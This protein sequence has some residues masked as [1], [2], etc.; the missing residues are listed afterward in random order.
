M[1]QIK[2]SVFCN[3]KKL[4]K[5]FESNG[6]DFGKSYSIPFLAAFF[7][8]FLPL[9][10]KF[11]SE[12][13][14]V[15]DKDKVLGFISVEKDER[16]RKRL[17]ITKVFLEKNSFDIGKL[18][19]QYVISRYCAMG[20][21][22]YQVVVDDS[23]VDMLSLFVDGCNFRK[24][25]TELIYKV[26][27]E[28]LNYENIC[29]SDG[30]KFYKYVKS[31]DVCRLYNSNINSYQRHS[32]SKTKEQF[33]P[34]FAAGLNDKV[35]FSY[36]L[37]DEQKGKIYGYFN[38]VTFNNIDYMLDFVLDSAFEIYFEDALCY[39]SY[40]LD[41]RVKNW[42]LYV[43]IKT[44]FSNY[45]FFEQYCENKNYELVKSSNILTKDYLKE[46]K[47][48]SLLNSAKIVFNDI[49]PAFKAKISSN[50]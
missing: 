16:S 14:V 46:I 42:N 33:E 32:F 23:Q 45:K 1:A 41:K 27:Q 29:I 22:S 40:C 36:V 8:H 35:S 50:S 21:I 12:S 38:I 11:L 24:N 43:K 30:F 26:R 2:S 9:R 5:V 34:Y 10:V 13:Y 39:I 18:L 44:Y 47:E 17:K 49:T 7:H 3:S 48:N 31:C 28:S 37:E 15:Y 19:V 6:F 25:A 4:K 20:A